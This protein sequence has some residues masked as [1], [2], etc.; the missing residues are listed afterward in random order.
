MDDLCPRGSSL[1]LHINNISPSEDR[2]DSLC[3]V[4]RFSVYESEGLPMPTAH[5]EVLVVDARGRKTHRDGSKGA[6]TSG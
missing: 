3:L 5:V 1:V 4:L 6:S 2:V